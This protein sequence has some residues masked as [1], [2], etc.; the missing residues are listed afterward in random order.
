MKFLK[1]TTTDGKTEYFNLNKILTITPLNG[2]T[3][4][5][6]MGA[7]LYWTVER[8]SLQVWDMSNAEIEG[9]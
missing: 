3:V 4:K 5:I 9:I 1:A 8:D 2:D 6:L 7:G